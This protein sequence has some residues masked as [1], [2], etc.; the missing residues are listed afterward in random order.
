MV[1]FL[2][3]CCTWAAE[4]TRPNFI[5]ILV[6]DMGFSDIGCY[7]SEIPTPN[8]DALA[9]RGIRFTQFYNGARCCPS[10]AALLTGR[11]SHE[12]GM[13]YQTRDMGPPS[14]RGRI[15]SGIPTIADRL[16]Q[17][18][19]STYMVG[20]WHVGDD[21]EYWPDRRGF[22]KSFALIGGAMNYWNNWGW[23]KNAPKVSLA[24]EGEPYS[25]PKDFYATRDFSEAAADY[26]L[27]H[28]VDQPFFMY[29]AYNAPHWPLHAPQ[30]DIDAFRGTYLKGW[31]QIRSDRLD[32]LIELGLIQDDVALSP[33]FH[34][35]PEYDSLNE[36]EKDEWDLRMALYAAVIVNLDRGIGR[37]VD[38]LRHSGQLENTLIVF[39]SDN[40]A[41]FEDPVPTGASW[42]SHPMDGPPGSA[43]SFPAYLTPWA[44]ASNT[45]FG[46]FKAYLHEGGIR[47]PLILSGWNCPDNMINSSTVGHI[48]D[49]KPTL[50]EL[51]GFPRHL[52]EDGLD[53]ESMVQV[54]EDVSFPGREWTFWEH[55]FHRAVRHGPWKLVS[56]RRI[57]DKP[58]VLDKWELY[59]LESDPT[60]LNDL[61]AQHPERVK[62][63]SQAYCDW[64]ERVGALTEEEMKR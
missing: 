26:I 62:E 25:V 45:P 6:D 57:L 30:A 1:G 28:N 14:Y 50:L 13:G 64:F 58:G 8:I 35:V 56:P 29:L 22:Q 37:V 19:Y 31:D 38:A 2:I 24:L 7:G 52:A 9:D 18:D 60:E 3:A 54:F 17:K 49:L 20:K 43:R 44:N 40:G 4:H 55:H 59:N 32:K 41:S 63:M 16:Q 33:R 27:E 42:T 12:V 21:R 48:M 47:T 23:T 53:G 39:L 51:A 34:S 5:I 46:H 10:R 15:R 36:V 11:Y 61:S